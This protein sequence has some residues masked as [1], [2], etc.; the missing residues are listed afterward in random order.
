MWQGLCL[1]LVILLATHSPGLA[2]WRELPSLTSGYNK[3]SPQTV[4][5]LAQA[6]AA[7]VR[8]FPSIRAARFKERAA[9]ANIT[10]AKTQ[11]LPYLDV[12]MQELRT[13]RN[14]TSGTIL[15]QV[16]EAIPTQSGPVNGSSSFSSI[17]ASNT[18]ANFKW[19]LYDFGL[20]GANVSLA[21]AERKLEQS[22][23]NLTELDV[24]FAAA[25]TYL[26]TVAA[27]ETIRAAKATLER[28]QASA[29]TV[30]TMV[31]NGLKPGVDAAKADYEV[32][33]A[34]IAV[35]QSERAT[36]LARVDLAERM[37]LAGNYIGI[38]SVPLVQRPAQDFIPPPTDFESHPL[39]ILHSDYVRTAKAKVHVLDRTWYPH[40]WWNS[41]IW[42][43]GSGAPNES[44]P[45]AGGAIPQ[46]ANWSAGI[47][48]MFPVMDYFPIKAKRRAAINEELSQRANFDLAI[49]ILEQKDARA[50]VLLKEALLIADETPVLVKAA[51][52]NEIKTLERYKV[53]LTNMVEVAEAER[54]LAKAEVEDALAQI[55]VWRSILAIGYVQGDLTPFLR[56]VA[57][58]EGRR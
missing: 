34:K 36:E 17:W 15:P 55:E 42:G 45:V 1:V 3:E 8:N 13:T 53:G 21:S 20:R 43:R 49:Q 14:V 22:A 27:N 7:A 4:Y 23:V 54:I 6:V 37:G 57:M 52:E 41:A 33:V 38:V 51:R 12:G 46:V 40:L 2:M 9:R 56:L 58:T 44:P 30:H 11:Y 50:R 48:L 5:T 25:D 47:A 24:A 26:S 28:M 29:V 31:D 39:A 32:S 16:L 19:L 18:A 35:I 10:L